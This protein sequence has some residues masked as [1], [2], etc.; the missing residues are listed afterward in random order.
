MMLFGPTNGP[1]TFITFI[2]DLDCV[3]KEHACLN[4]IP[5]DDD[6]N[7][8]II[9]DNIVSLAR[10]LEYALAYMQCQLK[11]YQAYN[12]SLTLSKSHLF[13]NALNLLVL[14]CAMMVI[15]L[16][17]LNTCFLRH[18]QLQN[19]SVTLQNLKALHSFTPDSFLI[20]RCM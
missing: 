13:P 20:L 18:G 11:V 10:Q 2:H 14:T 3:W 12:L 4:G 8:K 16:H 9:V 15:A 19:L 5:I 17:S 1:E 7:S 6:T